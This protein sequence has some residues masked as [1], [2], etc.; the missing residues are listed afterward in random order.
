MLSDRD[1][2]RNNNRNNPSSGGYWSSHSAVFHLIIINAIIFV[3]SGA[4]DVNSQLMQMGALLAE[5]PLE[6]HR[7]LTYQFLHADFWH[8]FWNMYGVW[9][10]GSLI[11]RVLGKAH[12]LTLYL[13]SGVIG[14]VCF[15]LAN[16]GM[17]ARCIGAS[18]ALYGVMVASALAFPRAQFLFILFPVKLWV[19]VL[20]YLGMDIAGAMNGGGNIAH[21]AHLGG[22]LGGFIYMRRLGIKIENL[23]GA[24]TPPP[25]ASPPPFATPKA[26]QTPFVY[27]QERLNAI[28]DK[29]SRQGYEQLSDEDRAY[30]R[31]S[32]EELKRRRQGS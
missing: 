11:E 7:L 18:G 30:L 4:G 31:A 16:L 5:R 13:V 9:L 2:Y 6:V 28:L 26:P 22:A 17:P 15:L 32:S 1:Y 14:G 23:F 3:L 27:D 8:I 24:R 25:K 21:L 12:F 29:M 20:I 19:M 10:F